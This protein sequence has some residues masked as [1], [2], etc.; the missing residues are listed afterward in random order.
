MQL[1]LAF[2][3]EPKP[4]RGPWEQ[5]PPQ[6][7]AEAVDLLAWLIVQMAAAKIQTEADDD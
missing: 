4:P 5:L 2:G 1:S 7:R 6:P 3:D